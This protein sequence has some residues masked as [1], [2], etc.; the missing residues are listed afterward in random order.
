[1]KNT[2]SK[3]ITVWPW[4]IKRV[5]GSIYQSSL[6]EEMLKQDVFHYDDIKHLR[7]DDEVFNWVLFPFFES[8]EWL[9]ES[10]LTYV[11]NDYGVWIARMDWGSADEDC[12]LPKVISEY[13][14]VDFT[15]KHYAEFKKHLGDSNFEME[16]EERKPD[17]YEIV[18]Y[19]DDN[20]DEE[21]EIVWTES[22]L[23][24][25]LERVEEYRDEEP[26]YRFVIN[27]NGEAIEEE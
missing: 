12:F 5:S 2:T 18:K 7:R 22:S 9:K 19:D 4:I 21:W 6:V 26:G 10:K 16:F 20:D 24:D 1:M 15:H 8:Y 23:E 27:K 11:E 13:L 25:V 14:N 17:E 3:K